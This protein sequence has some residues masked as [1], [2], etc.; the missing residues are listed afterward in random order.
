M[1]FPLFPPAYTLFYSLDK[2]AP[3]AEWIPQSVGS[4]RLS[5]QIPDLLLDSGYFFRIQARN[6][7]GSGPISDPIFF[8]T[9][10]AE[11]PDKMPN[12]QGRH[13]DGSYWPLDIDRSINDSPVGQRNSA[14]GTGILLLILGISGGVSVVAAAVGAWICSRRNEERKRK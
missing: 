2:N 12:D 4:E 9:A 3:L 1:P 14:P 5:H 8:R 6:S 10:K 7:K 11:I 13:G